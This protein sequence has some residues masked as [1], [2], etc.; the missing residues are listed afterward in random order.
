MS[1]SFATPWT[2]ACQASLFMGFPRILEWVASFLLQGDLHEPGI[3][4]VS[5]AL[6]GR[7]FTSEPSGKPNNH[8]TNI[9]NHYNTGIGINIWTSVYP[10]FMISV[11]NLHNFFGGGKCYPHLTN[12]NRDLER[13]CPF[14]QHTCRLKDWIRILVCLFLGEGNGTPLQYSCLENAMDRGAW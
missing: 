5:P 8:N 2:I 1:D 7:F 9:N 14:S 10:N 12:K 6:A 4:T 3:N 13:L 11:V